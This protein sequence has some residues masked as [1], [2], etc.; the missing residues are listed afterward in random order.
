[1]GPV[2]KKNSPV[3]GARLDA[4]PTAVRT[5][6]AAA[7][8]FFRKGYGNTSVQDVADEVGIL[9]G[10]LYYYIDSKDDLL[11]RLIEE[12]QSKNLE[13]VDEVEALT[14]LGPLDRLRLYLERQVTYNAANIN[15][16]T[17][18][19][20]DMD[21]LPP[22]RRKTLM[23]GRRRFTNFVTNLIEEARDAGEIGPDVNARLMTFCAFATTNWMYTWYRPQGPVKAA[24]MARTFAE[25]VIAGLTGS[26]G[27]DDIPPVEVPAVSP[28]DG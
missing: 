3:A 28:A 18:Y 8:L 22:E 26:R 24:D 1:M 10:S 15:R 4:R 11:A 25:F 13:I 5:L 9:K 16:I 19:Y 27:L 14:D 2:P 17:V 21:H 6:D 7:D 20:R 12:T 23:A